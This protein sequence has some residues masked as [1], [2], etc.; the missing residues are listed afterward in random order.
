MSALWIDDG[1]IN[2]GMDFDS[3]LRGMKKDTILYGCLFVYVSLAIL[4]V[5]VVLAASCERCHSVDEV[6]REAMYFHSPFSENECERCHGRSSQQEID[7]ET[8]EVNWF[9]KRDFLG[10]KVYFFL[11]KRL[12]SYTLVFDAKGLEKPIIFSP[13]MAKALPKSEEKP[14]IQKIWL[15]G[16][17]KGLWLEVEICVITNIPTEVNIS[18]NGIRGSSWDEYLTYHQISLSRIKRDIHYLCKVKAEDIFGNI[19]EIRDFSFYPSERS[20]VPL[21]ISKAKKI[22]VRPYYSPR[23]ELLL[24]VSADGRVKF[25]LGVVKNFSGQGVLKVE[26]VKDHPILSSLRWAALE[27]CYQCHNRRSLGASHPVGI[28]IKQGMNEGGLLPLY[29]GVITCATCHN[30][31]GALE[32]NFLRQQPPTLCLNCHKNKKVFPPLR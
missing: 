3:N 31:H 8:T 5:R 24:S 22:L 18:C 7:L 10:G 28:S 1:K 15:C 27:A 16:L 32:S 11:P 12:K 9:M 4:T 23:K 17:E 21:S 25:R 19:F 14:K 20:I 29:E 26:G 13:E 2:L 6:A 30:P